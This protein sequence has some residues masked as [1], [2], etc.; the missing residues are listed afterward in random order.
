MK[1]SSKILSVLALAL[2]AGTILSP[3]RAQD[4]DYPRQFSIEARRIAPSHV[5]NRCV[6]TPTKIDLVVNFDN[7]SDKLSAKGAEQVK[8]VAAIIN[9]PSF[10]GSHVTLDGYTD[11]IG[12]DS[13][14]IDLSYRR[15]LMIMHTLVDKYGVP[16]S[17]LSA[18]GFGKAN[19]VATNST[20]VGR[21]ANRRV[22]FEVSVE[23]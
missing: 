16:A 9:D 17:L 21:A 13:R 23:K 6:T 14:N 22:S 15:A 3:V 19:P 5:L 20:P 12:K 2:M 7:N 18:Q 8:K 10:V 4:S 1:S 11:A